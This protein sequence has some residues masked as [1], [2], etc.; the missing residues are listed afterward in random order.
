MSNEIT[1]DKE[2]TKKI[3]I[4]ID[5]SLVA[6][7]EEMN[8]YYGFTT[9]QTVRFAVNTMHKNCGKMPN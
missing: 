7:L 5:S 1:Q 4:V 8:K 3:T 9:S 2:R 6:K